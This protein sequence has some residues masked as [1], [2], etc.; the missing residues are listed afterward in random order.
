MVLLLPGM[1]NASS[2]SSSICG[3]LVLQKGS[4]ILLCTLL[5]DRPG[6]CPKAALLSLDDSSSLVSASPP[7]P[8]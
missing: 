4:K 5:E 1:K 6:P 8:D 2:S 3:V 7:F